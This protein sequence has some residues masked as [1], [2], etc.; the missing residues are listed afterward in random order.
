[1]I[2]NLLY[3][4]MIVNSLIMN[5]TIDVPVSCQCILAI[6]RHFGMRAP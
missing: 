3:C 5:S 4:V 1:M 6:G 2:M